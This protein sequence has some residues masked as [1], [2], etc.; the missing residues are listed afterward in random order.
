MSYPALHLVAAGSASPFDPEPVHISQY[1]LAKRR[2]RTIWAQK[3]VILVRMGQLLVDQRSMPFHERLRHDEDS[4]AGPKWLASEATALKLLA[5][6][7]QRRDQGR[8]HKQV[9]C[10]YLAHRK[11]YQGTV[12]L[13]IYQSPAIQAVSGNTY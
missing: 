5:R 3:S 13:F 4:E 11:V 7:Q 2:V 8:V 6:K 12:L 9:E 1:T 10:H